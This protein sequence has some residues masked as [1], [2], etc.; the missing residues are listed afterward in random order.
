MSIKNQEID[1][2]DI[3]TELNKIL[4]YDKN[5]P[6]FLNE[7]KAK[8]GYWLVRGTKIEPTGIWGTR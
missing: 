4:Q 3:A 5:F 8:T 7:F 2:K 1:E 6:M